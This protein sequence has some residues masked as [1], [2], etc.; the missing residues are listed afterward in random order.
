VRDLIVLHKNDHG[1]SHWRYGVL[2]RQRRL[3]IRFREIFGIVR[4]S[5]FATISD[6]FRKS[7][8]PWPDL[9]AARTASFAG[10]TV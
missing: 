9:N 2:Q 5:T 3:K 10:R 8:R 4:F 1:L 7:R 6:P